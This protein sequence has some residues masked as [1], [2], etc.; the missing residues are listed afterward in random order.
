MGDNEYNRR[1]G[2]RTFN[3]DKVFA[4]QNGAAIVESNSKKGYIDKRGRVIFRPQ[5]DSVGG[6]YDGISWV[7]NSNQEDYD[8]FLIGG[9]WGLLNYSRLKA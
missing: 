1:M 5:F 4:F 9:K 3:F 6:F 2:S 7:N 8:G